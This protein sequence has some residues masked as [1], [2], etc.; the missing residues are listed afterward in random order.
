[1]VT[2]LNKKSVRVI[3]AGFGAVT[4]L[5]S[6][7]QSLWEGVKKGS[8]AIKPVQSMPMESYQTRLGG[9]VK[10]SVF[11]PL[12]YWHLK[13]F[14]EP[15]ID[16]ALKAVEEA[17]T[18]SEIGFEQVPAQRW[19]V[20]MG[21]CM[22]GFP[23]ARQWY[24]G[25][26]FQESPAPE[27]LLF[28]PPQALA[29][30]IGGT[31]GFKGPLLSISTACAAG[32]NAIGY[33][34]ELIRNGHADVV[35]A[36]GSD[37]FSDVL[38]AG[39]N[40]LESLSPEPAS[41]YSR[42][43]KGLSLG[44][45]S[46]V[47]VLIREDIAKQIGSPILGQILAYGISADG[48][49]PTAPHP[50]GVG[51]AQAI[52]SALT[53]AGVSSTQVRYIN[54]HGTGTIKN[55]PASIKAVHLAL[56]NAA[57]DVAI[58]STKSMIGHLLG[59][60]GAVE[61]IVTLKALQE[62]I[63][64]PTANFKGKTPECNLDCIPNSARPLPMDVAI[65]NNFAFG[66]HN[67]SVVFA[68]SNTNV[69]TPPAVGLEQVVVTGIATL[70]P[71]GNNPD[72]VWNAFVTNQ[73]CTQLENG[74]QVG[75]VHL[76]PDG[77]LTRRD[78][79]RMD[80]LGILSVV[81]T[82]LVL[83]DAGI[84][85][86]P[87]NKNRIGV[88]FG[89]G[90]GPMESLEK[91]FHPL[92]EEGIKGAN[93][94][95]FPNTV[96]NAAAGLVSIHTGI[97]GPSSTVTVGHAAGASA[98][99]YGYDLVASGKADAMVCIATDTLTDQV[100]EGYKELGLLTSNSV[101]P[102]AGKGFAIAEGSVALV[103]ERVSSAKARGA[104]IYGQ[105]LG[106]GI[107]SDS[108]GV[109]R[110][111]LRGVGLEQA[112]KTAISQSNIELS[113]I[114]AIWANAAGYRPIDIAEAAVLR[115]LFKVKPDVITPKSL[116]GEP[117]GVG[118]ILNTALALKAWQQEKYYCAPTESVLV[119]SCSLGGTHFSIALNSSLTQGDN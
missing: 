92:L 81:A 60:A 109:G 97:T 8:V 67:A 51:A 50:E 33:A 72:E 114:T 119:N 112:M 87:Q 25:K 103:L 108:K 18:S 30:A 26:V 5:G 100:I 117:I 10:E 63:A 55:D 71:G 56:G 7:A 77:F 52:T 86:T 65:S 89:T 6:T 16:F 37:A 80:R 115:R 46:G 96:Y 49:H 14:R 102:F 93:P 44:E 53:A 42:D 69:V 32:G 90:I 110:F 113:D 88:I 68:R 1:M 59:A 104:R 28:S 78:R 99:C 35:L 11:P 36:G 95:I 9:E 57:K 62:Q 17:I 48:Y 70:T 38:F 58:S 111:N 2:S 106:Y 41:P 3:V 21:T 19:G 29:E 54:G 61:A 23:S 101:V 98:L 84:E 13:G 39:F 82:Q 22:A 31:F 107:A 83:Q 40:S 43:R 27:L 47:M 24:S 66:G 45:G 116:L 85:V 20:V 91:F 34:A 15:T 64:P 76:D 105:M 4:A 74:V 118:G 75:R 94:A 79:R 73:V 12:T